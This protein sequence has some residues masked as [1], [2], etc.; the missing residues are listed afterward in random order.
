MFKL[1][2]RALFDIA[3]IKLVDLRRLYII[4]H[5]LPVPAQRLLDTEN[6]RPVRPFRRGRR[7]RRAVS[8]GLVWRARWGIVAHAQ[9]RRG[10]TATCTLEAVALRHLSSRDR[11]REQWR[12]GRGVGDDR[13][14]GDE[15]RARVTF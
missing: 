11:E 3:M 4:P 13:G 8:A 10:H 9:E 15:A 6:Q 1:P 14:E 2:T 5:V 7:G 12:V